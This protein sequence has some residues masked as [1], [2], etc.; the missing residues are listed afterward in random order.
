MRLGSLEWRLQLSAKW[1]GSGVG[2]CS[3]VVSACMERLV[4][5]LPDGRCLICWL[6]ARERQLNA[7]CQHCIPSRSSS[8]AH[9]VTRLAPLVSGSCSAAARRRIDSAA[10]RRRRC[11][12]SWGGRRQPCCTGTGAHRWAALIAGQLCGAA[13]GGHS[14]GQGLGRGGLARRLQHLLQLGKQVGKGGPAGR[15]VEAGEH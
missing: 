7:K 6:Q 3:A 10:V 4:Y 15:E 5:N 9:R 12:I 13:S 8:D 1:C 11:R 2:D 14:G